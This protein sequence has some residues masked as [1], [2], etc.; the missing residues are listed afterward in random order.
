VGGG[1]KRG[2]VLFYHFITTYAHSI[3][4]RKEKEKGK[5]E[6]R[7]EKREGEVAKRKAS[8]I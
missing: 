1:G 5:R 8:Y 6:E 4:C 3:L 2:G 7:G